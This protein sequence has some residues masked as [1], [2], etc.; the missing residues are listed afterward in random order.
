VLSGIITTNQRIPVVK[1]IVTNVLLVDA[2]QLRIRLRR[3]RGMIPKETVEEIKKA[4]LLMIKA[5]TA[6]NYEEE[7]PLLIGTIEHLSNAIQMWAT[8]SHNETKEY[9]SQALNEGD[10]VYRP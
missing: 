4:D 1:L 9:L 7:R 2:R 5:R 10:G 8:A 3:D 6:K